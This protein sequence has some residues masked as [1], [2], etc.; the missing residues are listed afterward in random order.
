MLEFQILSVKVANV[1]IGRLLFIFPE[2][3]VEP[4]KFLVKSHNPTNLNDAMSLTRDLQNV[5]PRTRFLPKPNFRFERKPWIKD[6]P[7]N[8]FWKIDTSEKNKKEC[9][10]RDELRRNFFCFTC[11][12]P[13]TLGHKCAKGKYQYIELFSDDDEYEG[14]MDE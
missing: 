8:K 4:L 6:A 11:F 14:G 9:Q 13:W 10:N 5:L 12:Q 2:G 3:L 1:S 7:D